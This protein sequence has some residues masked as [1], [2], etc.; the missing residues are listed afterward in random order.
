MKVEL[1]V[2][3]RLPSTAGVAATENKNGD[4]K[5]VTG[6][7]FEIS[8]MAAAAEGWWS[9]FSMRYRRTS[10]NISQAKSAGLSHGNQ[11]SSG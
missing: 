11:N 2:A 8:L 6:W 10:V 3:G 5:A 4:S 1:E 9:G 7:H